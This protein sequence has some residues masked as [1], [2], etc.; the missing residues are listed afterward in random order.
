MKR[1]ETELPG[2]DVDQSRTRWFTS[3]SCVV[4]NGEFSEVFVSGFLVGQ[5]G[6]KEI[7][8]RNILMVSLAQDASVK[9]GKLAWAFGISTE[10]LRQ[11]R[12]IAEEQ[13]VEALAGKRRGG[14]KP[15]VGGKK[16]P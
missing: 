4:R 2:L 15:K 12:R 3:D 13:G 14:S 1:K 5:Y 8:A 7:W 6:P 10:R 11:L 16:K 9:P